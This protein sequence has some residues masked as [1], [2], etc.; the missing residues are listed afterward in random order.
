VIATTTLQDLQRAVQAGNYYVARQCFLEL[1]NQPDAPMPQVFCEMSVAEYQYGNLKTALTFGE[2]GEKLLASQSDPQSDLLARLRNN[3][4]AFYLE[5]GDCSRSISVGRKW[6]EGFGNTTSATINRGHM[7]FNLAV[8]YRQ[9]G[10]PHDHREAVHLYDLARRDFRECSQSLA[11]DKERANCRLYEVMALQNQ[12][13]LLCEMGNVEQANEYAGLAAKLMTEA[14]E[15]PQREQVLLSAYLAYSRGDFAGCEDL[16][17][18]LQSFADKTSARQHFWMEWLAARVSLWNGQQVMAD[19][20]STL[21]A[22]EAERSRQVYLI[23]L[24]TE[25]DREIR[26]AG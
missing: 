1:L 25:L 20:H 15:G 2:A 6:L 9:R 18:R 4:V 26:A 12:A 8:A 10:G 5:I 14:M 3:L 11:N 17:H 21:A 23:R 19:A 13:W 24:A 22:A 16:L 7:Y